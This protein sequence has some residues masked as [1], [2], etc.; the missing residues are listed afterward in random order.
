V[1]SPDIALAREMGLLGLVATGVCSMVGAGINVIPIMVQRNVPGIGPNVTLAFA[2]AM[3]PAVLA[4]LSYAAMASAMPRAGGSYVYASRSLHPYL[5]LLASFSQWLGLSFAMGVV[6]Y[7]LVP[8]VRDIA[9]SLGLPGASALMERGPLRLVLA[10]GFLWCSTF[11]NLLGIK[12]YERA[13]IAL[14]VLGLLGGVIVI[15]TGFAYGHAD[16]LAAVAARDGVPVTPAARPLETSLAPLLP[17]IAILFSS[18]IG[19]DSIAQTGSEARNPN[20][21]LPLAIG[22]SILGVGAFY[23]LFTAAVYH[24]VPWSFIAERAAGSDLTAPGLLSYLLAPFWTLA[25]VGFSA[26]ALFNSLPGMML[27]VSRLMFAWAEDGI[28]FRSV[29]RIHPRW[30]TP[31]VAILASS[32]TATAGIFG[33]HFAGDFFLGV[34]VLVVGM[35]VNFTLVCLSVV[36]LAR[37]NPELAAG[38][39][40]LKSR[41]TQILLGGAGAVL[42]GVLLAAQ[43]AKDLGAEVDE[44]YY[45]STWVYLL[46]VLAVSLLFFVRFRGLRKAGVD[47]EALYRTLPP[48]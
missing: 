30:R 36:F 8:F 3:V 25:I 34:D 1:R 5:G 27:A 16:F 17:A 7:V 24:A 4:A 9:L 32:F 29:S 12:I 42:L 37:N 6:A 13:M 14:M 21:T 47:L 44:W 19:F 46:A 28:F 2:L 26:F 22:I 18:F 38:F 45:R 35:L 40:V 41:A 23:L 48:E 31:H 43:I 39:R 33:C 20:V 11:L 15:A 10:L